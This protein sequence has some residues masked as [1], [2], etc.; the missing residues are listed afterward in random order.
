MF[1]K[2]EN[3]VKEIVSY[4]CSCLNWPCFISEYLRIKVQV[5]LVKEFTEELK[6]TSSPA[7]IELKRDITAEVII[8]SKC[9]ASPLI[10]WGHIHIFCVLCRIIVGIFQSVRVCFILCFECINYFQKSFNRNPFISKLLSP[11]KPGRRHVY[12]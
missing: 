11:Y 7:Y 10:R 12:L 8:V 5:S 4:Y 1:F 9:E 3:H 6:N 2:E